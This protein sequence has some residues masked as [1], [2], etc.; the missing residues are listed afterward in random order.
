MSSS[1]GSTDTGTTDSADTSSYGGTTDSADSSVSADTTGYAGSDTGTTGF[2]GSPETGPAHAV[3]VNTEAST[4]TGTDGTTSTVSAD[5]TGYNTTGF[6]GSPEMGPAHAVAV[7]T[8]APSWTGDTTTTGFEGSPEMGPAHAVAVNTD[9]PTWSAPPAESESHLTGFE[10]SPELGPVLAQDMQAAEAQGRFNAEEVALALSALDV[11]PNQ[12][13]PTQLRNLLATNDPRYS[14]LVGAIQALADGIQ[15]PLRG[16]DR[17]AGPYAARA[18]EG[19]DVEGTR[20]LLG[21]I[22]QMAYNRAWLGARPDVDV[23]T[24]MLDPMAAGFAL[25]TESPIAP[26]SVF[27]G[28]RNIESRWQQ[29]Q[30]AQ[31]LNAGFT[32]DPATNETQHSPRYSYDSTQLAQFADAVVDYGRTHQLGIYPSTNPTPDPAFGAVYGLDALNPV[33][34]P[35]ALMYT[36]PYM[37]NGDVTMQVPEAL[38]LRALTVNPEASWQFTEMSPENLATV[39]RPAEGIRGYWGFSTDEVGQLRGLMNE[40]GAD[41]VRGALID[42]VGN[43]LSRYPAALDRYA[44][45]TRLMARDVRTSEPVRQAFVDVL[46]AYFT[47][48]EGRFVGSYID[49]IGKAAVTQRNTRFASEAERMAQDFNRVDLVNAFREVGMSEQAADE[50]GQVMTAWTAMRV[51]GFVDDDNLQQS[52]VNTALRPNALVLDAVRQAFEDIGVPTASQKALSDSI[53]YYGSIIAAVAGP[54][55]NAAGGLGNPVIATGAGVTGSLTWA[56]STYMAD[57]VAQVTPPP[58]HGDDFARALTGALRE[59]TAAQLAARRGEAPPP[60]GDLQSALDRAFPEV[61][62]PFDSFIDLS[63][64]EGY[65]NAR[66]G[67]HWSH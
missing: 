36:G 65:L 58:V 24:A 31:L 51:A 21:A 62:D 35:A 45:V 38:A 37:W 7:N 53:K 39:V 13:S 42:A 67:T 2:E 61:G 8:D 32:Y 27:D 18:Y 55:A 52:E 25:A 17:I 66:R 59:S 60:P 46:G 14:Q 28:L 29:H 19:L 64:N 63:A 22:D 12:F 10:G 50:L 54:I 23:R 16:D 9:A 33:V 4:Y 30:L 43:E 11:D 34:N 40:Y 48:P 26:Q 57:R 44:D 41:V 47:T 20:A 5:T 15:N 56:G 3:A 6:E 49:D 1:Y